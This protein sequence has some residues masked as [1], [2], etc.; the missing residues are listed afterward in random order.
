MTSLFL[1]GHSH[2]SWFH[3]RERCTGHRLSL[4]FKQT[5]CLA[6][7][8]CIFIFN[9]VSKQVKIEGGKTPHGK[10]SLRYEVSENNFRFD[11][12]TFPY[13]CPINFKCQY[14]FLT[15][16][17]VSELSIIFL[18]NYYFFNRDLSCGCLVYIFSLHFSG[19]K[20]LINLR[21]Q[22]RVRKTFSCT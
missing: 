11:E 13:N 1:L 19:S 20:S 7:L 16:V 21:R 22:F 18:T 12:S 14:C 8:C 15:S 4:L 17:V 9:F 3:L 10:K 2:Y 6:G 5:D